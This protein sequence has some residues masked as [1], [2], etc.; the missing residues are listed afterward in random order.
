MFACDYGS[1][2]CVPADGASLSL[3]ECTAMCVDPS[4]SWMCDGTKCVQ[5]AAG[6]MGYSTCINNGPCALKYSARYTSTG[7][8]ECYPDTSGRF[9]TKSECDQHISMYWPPSSVCANEDECDFV[10]QLYVLSGMDMNA[11]I[12]GKPF[13]RNKGLQRSSMDRDRCVSHT[14]LNGMQDDLFQYEGVSQYNTQTSKTGGIDASYQ[15]GVYNAHAS[16]DVA[17]F[18]DMKMSKNVSGYQNGK[19]MERGFVGYV[20]QRA[21]DAS[22]EKCLT[23]TNLDPVML[24]ILNSLDTFDHSATSMKQKYADLSQYRDFLQYTGSH[25]LTQVKIGA[26]YNQNTTTNSSATNTL[27]LLKT[28]ACAGGGA[29]G[30]DITLCAGVDTKNQTAALDL[31][32]SSARSAVGGST[33]DRVIMTDDRHRA[34]V[35]DVTN[36]LSP[37]SENHAP[38]NFYYSPIWDQL[39]LVFWDTDAFSQNMKKRAKHFEDAYFLRYAIVDVVA[40]QTAPDIAQHAA[41]G[42]KPVPIAA[43]LTKGLM[44][45]RQANMITS[46]SKMPVFTTHTEL[47][48][49]QCSQTAYKNPITVVNKT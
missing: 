42:Y 13:Y 49:Y 37:K 19:V 12:N 26:T 44:A 7:D 24:Q 22:A 46:D 10:G 18:S 39:R 28:N 38:L 15:G 23:S 20:Q 16:F 30:V 35:E 45:H 6:T 1:H 25:V 40:P 29:Y 43:C 8:Q 41:I 36:F 14:K 17:Q 34:T 21:P 4:W 2:K 33:A 47:A 48:P 27:D 5:D 11:P 31:A 32:T 3:D 9:L